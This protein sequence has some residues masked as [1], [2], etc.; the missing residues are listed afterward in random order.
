MPA[1]LLA[2]AG[3]KAALRQ[4]QGTA[5][6]RAPHYDKFLR[7]SFPRAFRGCGPWRLVLVDAGAFVFLVHAPL[8]L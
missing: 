2:G 7:V 4:P 6:P 1:A 5:G 3:K 8:D